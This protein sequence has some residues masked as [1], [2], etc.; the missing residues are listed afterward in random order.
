MTATSNHDTGARGTASNGANEIP[1][2]FNKRGPLTDDESAQANGFKNKTE[3]GKAEAK[4]AAAAKWKPHWFDATV[5]NT[6]TDKWAVQLKTRIAD[7]NSKRDLERDMPRLTFSGDEAVKAGATDAQ[8]LRLPSLDVDR[9]K[10]LRLRSAATR[11]DCRAEIREMAKQMGVTRNGAG[12]PPCPVSLADLLA[13]PD[14]DEQYR[15]GR[16]WPVGG[17]ILLSAPYKAGKTSTVGNLLRSLVDGD[18]F[19]GEFPTAPVGRVVLID[20]EMDR[21]NIRRWLREQ[22]IR[23][24]AAVTVIP[25][26]GMVSSFAINNETVRAEWAALIGQADVLILDCLRPVLDAIGLSEATDAGQLLNAFDEL[27]AAVKAD[28]G[29]MVTHMGHANERAR[30]DSRLLDWPDVLWSIVRD[31]EAPAEGDGDRPRYFSAV[32]RD[33][34]VPEGQLTFDR[35]TRHLTYVSGTRT[36]APAR[37][38]MPELMAL[39]RNEPGLSKNAVE[40]R[41]KDDHGISQKAA[42]AAISK[43]IKDKTLIVTLGD[44]RAQLLSVAPGNPFDREGDGPP[45]TQPSEGGSEAGTDQSTTAT[46]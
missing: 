30:G 21:R 7:A 41:L 1:F 12:T 31:T 15:I 5:L 14:E 22:N 18:P 44:R 28:E 46:T 8:M 32:G 39:V 19:L 27:L 16:L 6:L 36:E 45:G 34:D 2:D 20:T 38:A 24:A 17:R 26:R 33:V 42:R 43:A 9:I 40:T 10:L 35:S 25:I 23:N 37:A 11:Q 29:V 4:D 3:Q 13:E